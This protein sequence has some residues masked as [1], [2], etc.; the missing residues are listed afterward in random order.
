MAGSL[1]LGKKCFRSPELMACGQWESRFYRWGTYLVFAVFNVDNESVNNKEVLMNSY[2]LKQQ[3]RR[4]RYEALAKKA[5]EESD[6]L[7]SSSIKMVES[8]PLGQP[9]LVGHYSENRDRNYRER[10]SRK[11]GKSVELQKKADHYAYKAAAVGNSGISSDDPDAIEKLRKKLAVLQE[12]QN[13][14]KA[15]NKAI[16]K[17]DMEALKAMGLCDAVIAA[18]TDPS[19]FGGMGYASFEL[20]NN[21]ANIRRI[22]QRISVLEASAK[23]AEVSEPVNVVG[24]GFEYREDFEENRLMF[25][26][27]GKPSTE[28]RTLLKGRGFKWSPTRGAWVRMISPAAYTAAD[29][30]RAFLR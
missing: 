10:A 17:E 27:D 3:R 21:N 18:L 9:I 4:E 1:W 11:M 7:A 12:K 19:K 5:A 16:R 29:S 24:E 23:H 8:I 28:V 20:S 30:I 13:H 25:I 15:V 26:F 22:E 6:R 14:M 2:E